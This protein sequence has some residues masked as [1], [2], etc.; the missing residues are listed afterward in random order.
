MIKINPLIIVISFLLCFSCDDESGDQNPLNIIE[1]ITTNVNQGDFLFNF[2]TGQ[3]VQE[4]NN[5]SWHLKYHNLDTGTGYKMPNIALNNTIL[6]GINNNSDFELIDSAP[7]RLSF[8]P[9]GGRMQYGGQNA[10]LS[11]DMIKNKVEVSSDTYLI[12]DT[13][14]NR[15]YKIIFDSYDGGVVVF[16]YSEL[17]N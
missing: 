15:I 12:Y 9:E 6:L 5:N 14:T 10:A 1:I 8:S 16:R 3:Q 4:V 11:Y 13:V 17:S 2:E 7:D